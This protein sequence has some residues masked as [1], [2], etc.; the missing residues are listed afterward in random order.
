MFGGPKKPP[1]PANTP[2]IAQAEDP[3]ER[4]VGPA[5]GSLITTSSRGLQRRASTQRTS[6]IGG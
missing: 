2:V 4:P 3:L 6:L 5:I 1:P